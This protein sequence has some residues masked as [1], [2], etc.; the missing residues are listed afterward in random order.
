MPVSDRACKWTAAVISIPRTCWRKGANS[1]LFDILRKLWNISTN[2]SWPAGLWALLSMKPWIC[3]INQH[4]VYSSSEEMRLW[5]YIEIWPVILGHKSYV[6]EKDWN[7]LDG[8]YVIIEKTR[9]ESPSGLAWASFYASSAC[10]ACGLVLNAG[11]SLNDRETMLGLLLQSESSKQGNC[12]SANERFADQ[13]VDQDHHGR[14]RGRKKRPSVPTSPWQARLT[15]FHNT[16]DTI[17]WWIWWQSWVAG[18]KSLVTYFA[19]RSIGCMTWFRLTNQL[20]LGHLFI[21]TTHEIS[22]TWD[23]EENPCLW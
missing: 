1:C 16:L 19:W 9:F 14:Y 11:L 21:Q 5:T 12:A 22:W 13:G 18:D 20:C 10:L 4:T 7:W 2:S 23:W 15:A 8:A 3:F 17:I 6:V